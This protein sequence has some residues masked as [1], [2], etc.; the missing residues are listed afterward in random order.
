MFL[1][2][3]VFDISIKDPIIYDIDTNSNGGEVYKNYASTESSGFEINFKTKYQWGYASVNYSYT[4]PSLL[5]ET[6]SRCMRC[7]ATTT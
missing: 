2:A 4:N 3:N 5:K 1:T 6:A 7:R